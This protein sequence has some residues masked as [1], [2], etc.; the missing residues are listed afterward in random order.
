MHEPEAPV[1][2]HQAHHEGAQR[3]LRVQGRRRPSSHALS[4]VDT[5]T[6]H[7]KT[8]I[9][10]CHPINPTLHLLP[11]PLPCHT[12]TVTPSHHTLHVTPSMSYLT[13]RKEMKGGVM[14][15]HYPLPSTPFSPPHCHPLPIT[16]QASTSLNEVNCHFVKKIIRCFED[17]RSGHG[18]LHCQVMEIYIARSWKF[19]KFEM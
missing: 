2:I 18:N 16:S 6:I 19:M 4:G 15:G 1:A 10:S 5:I 14:G 13:V 12:L 11:S 7:L 9:L 3:R 17:V 8:I